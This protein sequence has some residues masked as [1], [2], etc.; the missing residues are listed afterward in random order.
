MHQASVA[1]AIRSVE[2]TAGRFPRVLGVG[3]G[4]LALVVSAR[5]RVPLPWTPVPVTLQDLVALACGA[6]LGARAGVLA[7]AAYIGLGAVGLPVFASGAGLVY[8]AGPTGG[9]LLGFIAA[10]ALVGFLRPVGRRWSALL[11]VLLA[12][13]A[14]IHALGVFYLSQSSGMSLK[15]AFVAGSLTFW[16]ITVGKLGFLTAALNAFGQTL[17]RPFRNDVD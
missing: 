9:Y 4:I 6:I 11:L 12:G 8:L 14:L 5:V 1:P 3:I 17:A 10:A 13:E 2:T 7:T 15:A 16:P